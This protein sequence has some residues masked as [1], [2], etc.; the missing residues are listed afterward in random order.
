L[1]PYRKPDLYKASPIAKYN[2]F[3]IPLITV[4]G[5]IFGGFLTFL[6][7]EWLFDPWLNG[8][9]LYGISLQNIPSVIYMVVMYGLAAGIYY[10]FKAYRKKTGIDIEKVHQEIP[11]E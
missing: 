4:A 1:L 11:S 9:P 8:T 3:G 6:L 7:V 2:L 5:V 10:G